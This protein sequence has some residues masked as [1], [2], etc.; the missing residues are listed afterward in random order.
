VHTPSFS[1]RCFQSEKNNVLITKKVIAYNDKVVNPHFSSYCITFE[2]DFQKKGE[3]KV[4]SKQY[5]LGRRH[6]RQVE[7]ED[8][9]K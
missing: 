6:L 9:V 2:F 8:E 1:A 4:S 7:A 5:A 3:K